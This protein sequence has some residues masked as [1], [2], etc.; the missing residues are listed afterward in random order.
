MPVLWAMQYMSSSKS[1]LAQEGFAQVA[2]TAY[3]QTGE[4]TTWLTIS[5]AAAISQCNTELTF[6]LRSR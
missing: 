4:Q 5:R 1:T 2:Y 6:F 3:T